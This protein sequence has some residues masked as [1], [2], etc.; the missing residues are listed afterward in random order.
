MQVFR[1]HNED[2]EKQVEAGMKA[3]GT[4]L[5]YRTVYKHMQEFLD[6]RYHVK[7]IAL[8][9]LT[10]AFISDFEM[11][12]R[13]DKHCCTNTVWLYVCPLR[14]MVSSPST[15]SGSRATRSGS[16]KSKRRKRPAA[17]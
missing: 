7:D 12:L 1:Q 10:P 4:L 5:K 17:S 9:E 13:T 3:K 6:I 15:M 2:Y 14:T 11:F 16:M 8:K